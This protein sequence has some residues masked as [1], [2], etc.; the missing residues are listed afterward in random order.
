MN[1]SLAI[2]PIRP[3]NAT[4]RP[5]GSKSLTN[6]ALLLAALAQGQSVIHNPLLAD[7]TRQMLGALEALG[8]APVMEQDGERIRLTGQAGK[9]PNPS[10]N[11]QLHLGNAGTAF[12]FLTAACCVGEGTYELDGIERMRERPIGQLVDAL[13][14]IGGRVEYLGQE[15]YPPLRVTGTRLRGGEIDMPPTLSSQYISALL[16]IGPRCDEGISLRFDGPIVSRPYVEMTLR[17]MARFGVKA[18]VYGPFIRISVEPGTYKGAEYTVEPDASSASYFLAAA[19]IVPESRC[20][21]EGLGKGSL[22]GDVRFADV[23]H[24]MGAGLMFG[25]DFITVIAPPKGQTLRGID[26]D[27]NDMPDMAQTLAVVSL[28][29]KG[30]TTIRN[31]GNL[32]VKETDRIAALQNELAK[33]GATVDVQGDDLTITPPA[34]DDWLQ[35][36]QATIDTYN[37][38]RMA[39]SFAVAGLR[40]PGVV[41]NDPACVDKTFPDYFEQL[42][43]LGDPM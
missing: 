17:L 19:A 2:T 10:G 42:E 43:R 34:N 25:Q 30:Q 27:L 22:Q 37:D 13:R 31:V 4:V 15:G 1:D 3:F 39:M 36:R 18:N 35:G 38:H 21:I 23:L 12:R 33:L 14:G 26:V 6:R 11:T 24:E 40:M 8:L 41:I 29:A 5:P 7:D 20:T 16:Q 9:L 32:R 28:F